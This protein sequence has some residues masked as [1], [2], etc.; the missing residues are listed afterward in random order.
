M[1]I[2]YH[3]TPSNRVNSIL[4]KGLQVRTG[5]RSKKYQKIQPTGDVLYA[6]TCVEDSI[7]LSKISN[8]KLQDEFFK[9]GQSLLE[10]YTEQSYI[11]D[12][13]FHKGI[14]FLEPIRPESIRFH[15]VLAEPRD[16]HYILKSNEEQ[17]Q[18]QL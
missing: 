15:S 13:M 17:L 3:I 7:I 10:F 14:Y 4:K 2:F 1:P 8:W 12:E 6:T 9:Y 16:P 5:V 18:L 11:K